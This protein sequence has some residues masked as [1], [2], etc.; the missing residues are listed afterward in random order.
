MNPQ[1]PTTPPRSRRLS[2]A[3]ALAALALFV[4]LSGSA[5]AISAQ[6]IKSKHVRDNSLKSADVPAK[7]KAQFVV[8][9]IDTP[10]EFDAISRK[11]TAHLAEVFK[12]AGISN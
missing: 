12:E 10:E 11:E 6:S 8:P 1:T 3:H 9:V 7:L 5:L 4:S 2:S